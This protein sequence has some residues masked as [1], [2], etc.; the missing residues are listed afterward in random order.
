MW[1]DHHN[2][3]LNTIPGLVADWTKS[4]LLPLILNP[5]MTNETL[6]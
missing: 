6:D 1:L 2:L 5:G 4:V 3:S